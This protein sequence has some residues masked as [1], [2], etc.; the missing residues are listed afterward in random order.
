MSRLNFRANKNRQPAGSASIESLRGPALDKLLISLP[1]LST[2]VGPTVS[3][4]QSIHI[5]RQLD[6]S[7]SVP[8]LSPLPVAAGAVVL[9]EEEPGLDERLLP[10]E[11]MSQ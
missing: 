11:W 3:G 7:G 8:R 2:T 4:A 5:P 6:Y 9:T 1:V 10:E